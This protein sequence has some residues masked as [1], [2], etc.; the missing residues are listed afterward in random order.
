[1]FTPHPLEPLFDLADQLGGPLLEQCNTGGNR[2]SLFRVLLRQISEPSVLD[3]VV[4]EDIHWADGATLDLLR[5]LGRRLHDVSTLL[6]ATYRDDAVVVGDPLAV[7]LGDLARQRPTRRIEL[8]PLSSDAVGVLAVG[9]PLEAP[10][11][12]QLT[13]GNPFFVSEVLRAGMAAVPPSARDAVLA[14]TAALGTKAWD[15]LNTAA[16]I[17]SRVDMRLLE[18]ISTYSPSA[19]DELLVSGLLVGDGGELRFRHE[20]GRLAVEQ[21][22]APH[23]GAAIHRRILDAL[24]SSGSTEDARMAFHA[25]EAGDGAGVL[26]YAPAAARR[27]AG[28]ASHREAVAQFERALR[29]AAGADTTTVAGL[30]D[31]LAD[32]LALVDR[33]QEAAGVCER[34]LALWR[35]AGDRLREGDTLRRLSLIMWN[36]FR[37]DETITAIEAAVSVLEPQ[38]PGV[39]LARTYA[40]FATLR[41]YSS[42]HD[43]ATDLAVRAQEIAER[44]G[45]LDVLSDV[46]NVQAVSACNRGEEWVALM[47]RA[48]DIAL[49]ENIHEQAGRAYNNL[50]AV[51][52]AEWKFAEAERYLADGIAFCDEHDLIFYASSLRNERALVLERTGRWEESL[53]L[54]AELLAR[55]GSSPLNRVCP[56]TRLGSIHAR[57]RDPGAWEYLDEADK[58]ASQIGEPSRM[59]PIRLARA[60][61][62]WLKGEPE[63]A[64]REAE[65]ADDV[66]S[67]CNAWLRGAVAV[68]LVRTASTRPPGDDI[69]EPY[70][71]ELDGEWAGAAQYWTE[72]GCPYDA[73]MALAG[74]PDEEALSQAFKAFN[75]FGA[76]PATR[77]IREKLRQIGARAVPSEPRADT[78]AQ[79]FGLTQ[80]EREV[81]ALICAAHTNPE[82][83]EKLCISSKTVQNHVTAILTKMGVTNRI[84]AAHQAIQLGLTGTIT[85]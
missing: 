27:A 1:L 6:I 17:G 8:A 42:Q 60:E 69:A 74:A 61:A 5:F 85:I 71:L 13:G 14:R 46:L 51:Y 45:A 12:Y 58:A 55:A 77:I 24:V 64:A 18:S 66:A 37:V 29:F 39:E 40:T 47:S 79:P 33:W 25:E 4:V 84:S 16:L 38:G 43:I 19:I 11:L 72:L 68:W 26:R 36:L 50:C 34:A 57:R 20:I 75:S 59:V 32:E 21:A 56:L 23:R 10:E 41:M 81:L 80:R 82:I 31:G 76:V 52:V 70:R 53:A 65:R 22:I 73:A 28:L 35:K 44:V 54:S 2:D 49:S 9:S 48:L 15:V 3:V 63:E 83:A 7:T 78:R 62:Y 67:T 30:C